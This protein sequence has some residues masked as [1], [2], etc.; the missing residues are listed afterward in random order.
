MPNRVSR[1]IAL[2]VHLVHPRL[3]SL[4]V[5]IDTAL[6]GNDR[7]AL[8]P[9]TTRWSVILIGENGEVQSQ[10]AQVNSETV[11]RT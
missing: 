6:S 1:L 8:A 11:A 9:R 3:R 10:V 7:T 2:L 4:H 5:R